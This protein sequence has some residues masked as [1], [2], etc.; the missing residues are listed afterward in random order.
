MRLALEPPQQPDVVALIGE[1]DGYQAALYPP[2]SCYPVAIE[3]L[4][5]PAVL[6]AVA[7]DS[8]GTAIGCG[9]VVVGTDFGEIKRMF[10]R[11]K[12]RGRGAGKAILRFLEAEA[13]RAGCNVLR[14]ETGV[15]QP[16]A[17]GLYEQCGYTRCGPFANYRNDPLCVFMEKKLGSAKS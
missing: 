11:P 2:D 6:F 10:V 13:A 16:E 15:R 3:A 8:N 4:A 1:L 7:R 5:Q 14:L 9:A 17:L 12:D